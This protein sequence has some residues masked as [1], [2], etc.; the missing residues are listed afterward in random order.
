MGKGSPEELTCLD[1]EPNTKAQTRDLPPC[2]K[3]K[4]SNARKNL[5][6]EQR[7]ERTS[8]PSTCTSLWSKCDGCQYYMKSQHRGRETKALT[9]RMMLQVLHARTHC[10]KLP[11]MKAMTS[12]QQGLQPCSRQS[13]CCQ[14]RW[15]LSRNL[16]NHDLGCLTLLE[17]RSD[18]WHDQ[19][20][21]YSIHS[22]SL[23][24][25]G[26]WH[27]QAWLYSIHSL[28]LWLWDVW[29][30]QAWSGYI[31]SSLP[32]LSRY[33]AWSGLTMLHTYSIAMIKWISTLV[34]S[35]HT[36]IWSTQ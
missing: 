36:C 29:H 27:G 14:N 2:A 12:S 6:L 19:A 9:R 24:L 26:V 13:I 3:T 35:D 10:L 23:W 34:R 7:K 16:Q 5:P 32:W 33:L 4:Q 22:L 17:P 15:Q 30:G 18:D 21:L 1:Y 28:S 8:E 11:P 20:W 31:H 25:W